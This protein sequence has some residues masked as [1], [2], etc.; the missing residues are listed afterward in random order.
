[1]LHTGANTM[2]PQCNLYNTTSEVKTSLLKQLHITM[3][4]FDASLYGSQ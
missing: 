3:A 1:M 4:T 2:H